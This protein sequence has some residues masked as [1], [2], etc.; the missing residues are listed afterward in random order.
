[1]VLKSFIVISK[2]QL[3]TIGFPILQRSFKIQTVMLF[4]NNSTKFDNAYFKNTTA[5][6]QNWIYKADYWI[7]Q[8]NE[9]Q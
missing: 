5:I 2:W 1:M 4:K 3:R 6:F 7:S 9:A 8:L